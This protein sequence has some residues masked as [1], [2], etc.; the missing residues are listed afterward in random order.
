MS[1]RTDPAPRRRDWQALAAG[2]LKGD[3]SA[4]GRALTLIESR[5][6]DDW[7]AAQSLL[8]HLL[9]YSGKA[10]RVGISGV[11]G[12]GK[13]TFIET[14]GTYLTGV[15]HRVAVLA[16]DP[17]SG[18]TGGSILGDKTRMEKLATDTNAFIRPSPSAGVLGGVAR[19]TREAMIILEAAG[20][21]VVLIET[22]GTGQ[23]ETMVSDMVD[24]FLVLM[25]PGAGDDLQG[26]KKGI[27]ELADIIA[28][29]KADVFADKLKQ[30]M[31]D[32][33]AALHILTDASPNW[34]PPVVACSGLTGEG[35]AEL[36]RTVEKHRRI[37]TDSG[38]RDNRRRT[39]RLTWLNTQLRDRLVE[40]FDADASV[41]AI[42]SD[43]EEDVLAGRR[44]VSAA[45]D[46]LLSAWTRPDKETGGP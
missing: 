3:R 27:L 8:N 38:E 10:Q 30:S 41:K 23:S 39:Q 33:K 15:E 2:V 32:Y 12:V 46:S 7:T 16:V 40:H 13:S 6:A 28:L 45:V 37:T 5:R 44:T 24:L 18:R 25:L 29:N 17:S 43:L 21:D 26:I 35:V 36:W 9:P 14:L 4:I 22:V 11:P 1:V 31:R 42:R 34:H 19:A 20:F